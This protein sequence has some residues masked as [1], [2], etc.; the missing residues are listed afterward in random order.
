MSGGAALSHIS[1]PVFA[2]ANAAISTSDTQI[3]PWTIGTVKRNGM[4]G[5]RPNAITKEWKQKQLFTV[6]AVLEEWIFP[7]F[8]VDFSRFRGAATPSTRLSVRSSMRNF[9]MTES[10]SFRMCDFCVYIIGSLP[11][12]VNSRSPWRQGAAGGNENVNIVIR[13][14]NRKR[15]VIKIILRSTCINCCE[16]V[17]LST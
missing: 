12:P 1:I 4:V 11:L 15:L 3:I 13:T 7:G 9:F 14:E 10:P 2:G 8:V 17:I 5:Y 6:Y 16:R